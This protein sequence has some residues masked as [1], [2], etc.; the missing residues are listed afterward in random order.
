MPQAIIVFLCI[1]QFLFRKKMSAKMWIDFS[2]NFIF[3][4]RYREISWNVILITAFQ[5]CLHS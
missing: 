5:I 3:L 4:L 1:F 2:F